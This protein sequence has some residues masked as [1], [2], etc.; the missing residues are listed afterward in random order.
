MKLSQRLALKYIRTRL[1]LLSSISKKKAAEKAFELFCTPQ[2]RNKK[3]L[4]KIFEQAESL[5]FK[6]EA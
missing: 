2:Q 1:K 4:T 3:A 6:I 5:H